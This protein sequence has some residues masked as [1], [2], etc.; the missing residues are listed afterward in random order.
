MVPGGGAAD[1]A[2]LA[3]RDHVA[4]FPGPV[5][6]SYGRAGRTP[7]P[8]NRHP[9]SRA[10]PWVLATPGLVGP[11][12]PLST[13]PRQARSRS[14]SRS[15]VGRGNGASE[16]A[17]HRIGRGKEARASWGAQGYPHPTVAAWEDHRTPWDILPVPT[18]AP[19]RF[20][21]AVQPIPLLVDAVLGRRWDLHL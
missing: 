9:D 4:A 14:Q 3:T 21:S 7:P 20:L 15:I 16:A 13:A 17:K 8:L 6:D 1:S 19:D 10:D 18:V 12:A 5:L 11:A 2:V